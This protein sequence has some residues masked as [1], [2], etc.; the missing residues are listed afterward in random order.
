M[1]EGEDKEDKSVSIFSESGET[2]VTIESIK[3]EG[4]T[5]L[6]EGKLMGAWKSKMYLTPQMIPR[7]VKLMINTSFLS[8][9]FS[10]PYLLFRDRKRN[11]A[12]K[13]R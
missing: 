11:I 2:V 10:V 9:I 8:Y 13:G 5:L 4:D 7:I 1:Q 6:M 3:R 12:V